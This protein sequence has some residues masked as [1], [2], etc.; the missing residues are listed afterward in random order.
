ME[1][2]DL[3]LRK[4]SVNF[5]EMKFREKSWLKTFEFIKRILNLKS[6]HFVKLEKFL[7]C[8]SWSLGEG[9]LGILRVILRIR[10]LL[11][12]KMDLEKLIRNKRSRIPFLEHK[13][14]IK[15]KWNDLLMNFIDQI[16]DLDVPSPNIQ[17]HQ[18]KTLDCQN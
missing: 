6:L 15:I 7:S 5:L 3:N 11:G 16:V 4:P 12:Y 14:T 9:E 8:H 13:K 18:K 17:Y 2:Y 10:L 1:P